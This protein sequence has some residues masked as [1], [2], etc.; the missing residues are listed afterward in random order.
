MGRRLLGAIR[1]VSDVLIVGAG[2]VCSVCGVIFAFNDASAIAG[3]NAIGD[4]AGSTETESNE[5][6]E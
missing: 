4:V 2:V 5:E 6:G 3:S 1:F